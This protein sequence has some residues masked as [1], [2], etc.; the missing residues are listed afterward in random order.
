MD[1][2]DYII[3]ADESGDHSLSKV[4][5]QYPVF[6]LCLCAFNKRHYIRQ[7]VPAV[8]AFKF[9]WFGH[10]TIILHEREIRKKKPPFAFLND[11]NANEQFLEDLNEILRAARIA[12]IAAVIDKRKLRD[13]HLFRENPYHLALGFCLETT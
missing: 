8:Q 2:S 5:D 1:F 11:R 12:M 9:K 3:Y 4:D 6:V 13:E 10:D 7:I